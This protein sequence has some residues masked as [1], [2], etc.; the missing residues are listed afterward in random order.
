MLASQA[1]VEACVDMYT[2][3]SEERLLSGQPTFVIDAIDNIDTKVCASTADMWVL[4]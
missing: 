1:E 3:E 2:Q 4:P